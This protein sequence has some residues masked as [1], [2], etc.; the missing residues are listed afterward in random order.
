LT[1][2]LLP[3]RIYDQIYTGDCRDLAAMIPDSSVDL[4]CT[5]P[6]YKR[7][8]LPLYSWLAAEARRVLKPEGFLLA[9]AGEY[10]KD[11]IITRLSTELEYYF[12]FIL[13][14]SGPSSMVWQRKIISRHKSI[15]AYTQFSSKAKPR[16]NVL[17][18]LKGEGMDKRFHEW[19]QDEGSIRYYIDCFTKP[20]DL[21]VD[22]FCGGGT[23]PAACQ[24][25]D[26]RWLAFELDPEVARVAR[27]R[28]ENG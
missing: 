13:V 18:L 8:Y 3:L 19:G 14:N 15:L 27:A 24:A 28:V 2:T 17:S 16:T 7:R 12:D 1:R 20:G 9:Y 23:V 5:D 11:D 26:R 10:W 22:F 4:I 6:P 25:L 21:V